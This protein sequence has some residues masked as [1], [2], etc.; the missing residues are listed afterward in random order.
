MPAKYWDRVS[1]GLLGLRSSHEGDNPREDANTSSVK[2]S[3][4]QK[5]PAPLRKS[6]QSATKRPEPLATWRG[7]RNH[8]TL[9]QRCYLTPWYLGKSWNR[10]SPLPGAAAFGRTTLADRT[11][12][13]RYWSVNHLLISTGKEWDTLKYI[14]P[15]LKLSINNTTIRMPLR[16]EHSQEMV[17]T[18]LHWYWAENPEKWCLLILW[19]THL[20][21]HCLS[22]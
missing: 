18:D 22:S 16:N 7:E 9:C 3:S 1:C 15:K 8:Y 2:D 13:S 11:Y 14:I 12:Q 10:C 6:C 19:A 5:S 17:P 21:G 4:N 20:S